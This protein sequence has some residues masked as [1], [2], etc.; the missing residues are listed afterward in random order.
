[1]MKIQS[2]VLLFF[3]SG[4]LSAQQ[5]ELKIGD[6]APEIS[7]PT[8]DGEILTLSSL[9]GKLVLIDFWA[10]WCG[11]CVTEQP[12]LRKIYDLYSNEGQFEILGVSLDNKKGNWENAIKKWGIVWPQISDLKYWMS[13]VAD[14]Y[15]INSLPYNLMVG[16]DGNIL[17]FDLHADQLKTFLE[18]YFKSKN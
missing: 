1:M 3:I 14:D 6:A 16:P 13:P 9:K 18:D 10:S 17:A 15:Q 2:I 12:E 7:L 4:F 11:P 8:P 5:K